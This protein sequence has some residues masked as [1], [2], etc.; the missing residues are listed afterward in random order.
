VVCA[1]KQER[2]AH[3]NETDLQ[4]ALNALLDLF[5]STQRPITAG[6]ELD[7]PEAAEARK[8]EPYI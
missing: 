5:A 6:S 8:Y 4:R 7:A 2:V 3:P 1:P